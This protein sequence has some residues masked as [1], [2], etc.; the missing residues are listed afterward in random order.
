VLNAY[1]SYVQVEIQSYDTAIFSRD[2][3]HVAYDKQVQTLT[4]AVAELRRGNI[5]FTGAP[6]S[7]PV[8]VS[9]SGNTATVRDCFGSATWIPVYSSGPDRGK[10]AVAAGTTVTAHPVTATLKQLQDGKW[11]VVDE[12]VGDASC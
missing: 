2:L 4:N 1:K 6:N 10:S 8:V 12:T 5:N 3:Q 9:V 11:Y 7:N